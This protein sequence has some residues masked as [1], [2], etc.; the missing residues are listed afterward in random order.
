MLSITKINSASNQAKKGQSSKGYLHYLGG[1]KDTT[2]QRGDFDDYARGQDEGL[3][4]PPFWTGGGAALLGL[5]GQAERE[6]VEHLAKGF[7]PISGEA[8][9]KGAGDNHVMGLDMTF[10]AVKDVS[11]IFAGADKETRDALITC[12][13]GSAKSALAYVENNSTTRHGQGGR[14]KQ[15]AGAT[16]SACYTHFSSRAGEPQLHIHGF[17][18]NLAKRKNSEE[19]SALEHRA[20][21]EAKIATG[22]LFRVELASRLRGLG[23]EVEPAGPYFTIRGIDQGQR[24]ALSTRSKQIA[25]YV[26]ECGMLGT[27]GAVARE[28]AALNTRAAKAEPSLPDLLE[29]FKEMAAKLGLT[30]EAIAS[31]QTGRGKAGEETGQ[32]EI[33]TPFEID[34]DAVLAELMESQSCATAQDALALIC[35]KAMGQW[36]AEE[37]LA[38]LEQ[39]MAYSNVVQL[40]RTEHL[41]EIFTSKATLDLEASISAAVER[42]SLDRAHQVARSIVGHEFDRLEQELK[43]KLGV[44]VSLDQQRAAALHIACDTGRHAFVEGWAG[45]GKTTLLKALGVAYAAA[46]FNVSGCCQSAAASLNLAREADIPSRTIAS[47]LLSL[48]KGR[49]KLD[50]KSILILDEAGMVGS[51]EFGLLQAEAMKAGAKLVSV[52]DAKQLQPIDAGGIFRALAIRHGKAEISNIQRQRTDFSPLLN[53]LD[54]RGSLTKIQIQALGEAPEEARLQALESICSGDAKLARAFEKWRDRYDFEWMRKAVELFATGEAR[55]GLEMLDKRGRLKLVSGHSATVAQLV[56]AWDQ[57]KAALPQKAIIA[58]TRAEV[59]E[60]N[61]K[62][63]AALVERGIVRDADG[64]EAEIIHRD[65]TTDIKR[66]APGDRIVFTKNDRSLGISNGVAASIAAIERAAAGVMLVVELDE[67]NERQEKIV[68]IPASFG[69]FDHAFCLTNH[70]S[71]GRTFESA[72]VLVNPRMA[73][74]EWSYVAASRSR[75]ATTIYANLGALGAGDPE[76]HQQQDGAPSERSKAM[77]VLAFGMRRSRAKGTTL[78]YESPK[79]PASASSPRWATSFRNLI[80]RAIRRMRSDSRPFGPTANG[81]ASPNIMAN[82]GAISPAP[83]S[84][85]FSPLSTWLPSSPIGLAVHSN[86]GSR[87]SLHG[88]VPY[89]RPPATLLGEPEFGLVR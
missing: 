73:D 41:T 21:F 29:S 37:C 84:I 33:E 50:S 28:I 47:L 26:R 72:Y 69:R 43:A 35:E 32:P 14:V 48:Q 89:K 57:D 30:P 24:D 22:I 34:R 87:G 1:P 85:R 9:V 60:L 8:L 68:R 13:Q 66:F 12:L 27:D 5:S 82:V 20:Q 23:F 58:G 19:W 64:I 67:P 38:E 54:A 49:M 25:E 55:A 79:A 17:F 39:F 52:G 83:C 75:F 51:R 62:A 36:S 61:A 45:T 3:G 4:P 70:K 77:D 80:S 44:G 86:T 74:R 42:L 65:D 31:M 88:Q 16:I 2:R 78:D 6:H 81:I 11:A 56:E 46:G 71:Q 59:A 10:S 63:R 18:F 53:W 76:S 40:G 15:Q 7:H